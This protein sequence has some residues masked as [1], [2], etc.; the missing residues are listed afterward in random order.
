MLIDQRAELDARQ[1]VGV[2]RHD[3]PIAE[4]RTRL[5]NAAAAALKQVLWAVRDAKAP[6]RSVADVGSHLIAEVVQVDD[7]VAQPRRS[8]G[9]ESE[10]DQRS[11]EHLDE[12][13]R[14]RLAS[15]AASACRAPPQGSSRA[16]CSPPTPRAACGFA[17]LAVCGEGSSGCREGSELGEQPPR[18]RRGVG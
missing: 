3:G 18:G 10:V 15:A 7:D 4:Q 16:A 12:R 1:R 8:Q 17:G 14:P 11:A 9:A 2:E 5:A 6:T 13:L